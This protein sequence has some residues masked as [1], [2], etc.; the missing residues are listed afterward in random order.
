[1]PI[2]FS[3]SDECGDYKP[4][5]N[6]KQRANHPFYVRSC[7]T[8]NAEEWKFLKREFDALKVKYNLPVSKEIKWAYLWSLRHLTKK[9]AGIPENHELKF[10]EGYDYHKLI[11]FVEESLALLQKLN[12]KCIVLTYTRNA[13]GYGINEKSMLC[14]H[15]QEHMQRIEMEMQLKDDNLAVIF[16]DP[17]SPQKNELFREIYNDSYVNGDFVE[18][19]KFIKDSL[20][21]EN[22]HHSVGIQMADYI[23]G[24]FSAILKSAPGQDYSRGVKMF[25]ESVKPF[26]R[27]GWSGAIQGYG[28]REVPRSVPTRSWLVTQLAAYP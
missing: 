14:F 13:N 28:I 2:Y 27:R 1:M 20:N 3:F 6:P 16:F 11:D 18:K 15:L 24:A 12:Q 4:H 19:Y 9:G 10:L 23:S 26:L 7:L 8:M 17:V 21:I 22:S 25:N 5:M